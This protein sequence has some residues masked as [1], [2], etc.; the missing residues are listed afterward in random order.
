MR[1]G[2]DFIP[3]LVIES[4][5]VHQSRQCDDRGKLWRASARFMAVRRQKIVQAYEAG[6][7]AARTLLVPLL[8]SRI[9]L[10]MTVIH[11]RIASLAGFGGASGSPRASGGVC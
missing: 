1:R 7:S 3:R 8:R 10:M 4:R 2:R 6:R 9:I 5:T 11:M